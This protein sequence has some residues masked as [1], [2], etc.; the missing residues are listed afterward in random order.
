MSGF[1]LFSPFNVHV[2]DTA[3]TAVNNTA[4]ATAASTEKKRCVE[5]GNVIS[6]L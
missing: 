4:A 2:K 5:G 6:D 1:G 3:A